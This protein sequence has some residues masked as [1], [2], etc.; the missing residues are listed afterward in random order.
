[1][2]FVWLKLESC[3]D[4]ILNKID[5]KFDEEIKTVTQFEN[6]FDQRIKEE[7]ADLE[8]DLEMMARCKTVVN[9]SQTHR[10]LSVTLHSMQEKR[11]ALNPAKDVLQYYMFDDEPAEE[12]AEKLCLQVHVQIKDMEKDILEFDAQRNQQVD[13]RTSA[14]HNTATYKRKMNHAPLSHKGIEQTFY[15][16]V[17][18]KCYVLLRN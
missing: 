10:S 9:I 2:S 14:K 1:M 17:F 3:R 7:E 6:T 4:K 13:E 18:P 11:F 8:K 5:A 16:R 12:K 15:S